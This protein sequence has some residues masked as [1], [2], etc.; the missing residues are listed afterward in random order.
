MECNLIEISWYFSRTKDM[1][2]KFVWNHK[3]SEIVKV[4]L[5]KKKGE[6]ESVYFQTLAFIQSYS[7]NQNS[8]K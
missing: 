2:L 1:Y 4:I 8:A 3:S 7:R 5:G 6:R